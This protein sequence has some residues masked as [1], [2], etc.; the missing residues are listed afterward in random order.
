MIQESREALARNP[1]GVFP[2][3]NLGT[4]YL[5]LD[6]YDEAKSTSEKLVSEKVENPIVHSALFQIAFVQGDSDGMK[7]HTEWFQG[8]PGEFIIL[9]ELARG[10]GV[11]GRPSLPPN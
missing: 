4:G 7:R 3:V 11:G 1:T 2:R 9:M 8:K 6:R 10:A 5:A